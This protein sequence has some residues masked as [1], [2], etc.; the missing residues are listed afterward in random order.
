MQ[1]RID[2]EASVLAGLGGHFGYLAKVDEVKGEYIPERGTVKWMG[3][4]IAPRLYSL[5]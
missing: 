4:S 2:V 1:G 5:A 3:G